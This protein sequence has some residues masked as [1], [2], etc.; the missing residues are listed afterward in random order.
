M[1]E[2][3]VVRKQC[4]RELQQQVKK[5]MEKLTAAKLREQ[6]LTELADS[7]KKLKQQVRELEQQWDQHENRVMHD[8]HISRKL[9]RS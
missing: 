3:P 1:Q 9:Q 4:K 5:L 8:Y 7:N 6:D 2:P